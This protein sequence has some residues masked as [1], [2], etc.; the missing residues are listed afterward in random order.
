MNN[1][2]ANLKNAREALGSKKYEDAIK[3]C[4]R[5]LDWESQNY[6][7]YVFLGVAHNGL[8][9]VEDAENA[10]QKAIEINPEQMLAWQGLVSFYEKREQWSKLAITLEKLIDT[11]L[12]AGDGVRLYESIQ[13][14]VDIY[15]NKDADETKFVKALYYYLPGS[16]YYDLLTSAG[17]LPKASTIWLQILDLKSRQ[18]EQHIE[19]EIKARRM[20]INA[21]PPAKLRAQVEAEITAKSDLGNIFETVLQD[22]ES[23]ASAD[24]T[25]I[26]TKYFLFLRKRIVSEKDKS[27]TYLKL[28]KLAEHLC[29]HNVD[30]QEPYEF[31]IESSNVESYDLYDQTFCEQYTA[32]FPDTGLSKLIQGQ[33]LYKAGDGDSAFDFFSD[34][35]EL[36]PESL[37]GYQCLSW[38]YCDSKEYETGLEYS[39][40]GR[41][42]VLQDAKNYGRLLDRVLLSMELCMATCYRKID[43][44]YFPDAMSLYKKIIE[45]FP[46]NIAAKN[47]YGLILSSLNRQQDA[48][49]QFQSILEL[50]AT[51]HSAKVEIG[52]IYCQ[53]GKFDEALSLVE[54]AIETSDEENPEYFYRL[55][56]IYWEMGDEYRNDKEGAYK[57]FIR[58]VKIDPHFGPAF[59]YLGHFYRL[60]SKDHAKAMKCY[61]KALM[62]D[63]ADLDAALHLVDYHIADKELDQA[64][65]ILTDITNLRTRAGWPWRRLGFLRMK[66]NDCLNAIP[67]FQSALRADANDV[68]S[69][70]GLAES[71]LKEGRYTAAMKAFVRA[72]ELAPSNVYTSYQVAV[73]KQ[74]LGLLEEAIVQYSDTLALAEEQQQP[75]YIPALKGLADA[76]VLQGRENFQQ[77]FY[78]RAAD[79]YNA[80][81]N[82]CLRGLEIHPMESFW[83]LVGCTFTQYRTVMSYS[84]LFAFEDLQHIMRLLSPTPNELLKLPED[85]SSDLVAEFLS[86]QIDPDF[87]LPRKECLDVLLSCAT[88]AYKQA[89]YLASKAGS[90]SPSY[91]HDLGLTYHWLAENNLNDIVY[92]D[93][94]KLSLQCIKVALKHDQE[95][96]TF[97]NSLG[98]IA[99][100][101]DVKISQHAFIKSMEYNSRSAIPWSNYGYLCLLQNDLE[102]ASAAF[103]AAQAVDPEWI[104]SWIGQAYVANIWGNSSSTLFEH[105]FDTSNGTILDANYGYASSV[106]SQV[107]LHPHSSDA[108]LLVSPAFALQKLTE[109]NPDNPAAL[110][111]YGLILERL[112]QFGQAAEAYAGSI[113]ALEECMERDQEQA[114]LCQERISKVHANLARVLCANGDFEGAISSYTIA[115]DSLQDDGAKLYCELGAG[116]SYYFNNQLEEAL[117]MFEQ[118]LTNADTQ[119]AEMRQNVSVLLS[120]VLWALGGEEQRDLAQQELFKCI[121]DNPYHLAS[122]FGLC[123]MGLIQ[124]NDTL[125]EAAVQEMM[126]IPFGKAGFI[127]NENNGGWLLSKYHELKGSTEGA[128]QALAKLVHQTPANASLWTAMADQMIG[129]RH[130]NAPYLSS[131]IAVSN[132]S[133]SMLAASSSATAQEKSLAYYDFA[134]A[135]IQQ[136][137][138]NKIRKRK[139]KEAPPPDRRHDIITAAQRAVFLAPWDTKAWTLLGIAKSCMSEPIET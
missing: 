68:L 97:W 32:K 99:L 87:T 43:P 104:S 94:M 139:A 14:L 130:S 30:V 15:Q 29:D 93:H 21:G 6:N 59:T 57:C 25:A 82:A 75:V 9:Q 12:L 34:G 60:V 122:I 88:F 83:Q 50:D 73:V 63:P 114:V 137:E 108:S 103:D 72:R 51:Q 81:L 36:A 98:V 20:R 65:V 11:Y 96:F 102:L 80:A 111:V 2:K 101:N 4:K 79:S 132:T 119:S 27:K 17:S 127:D 77:G 95:N 41:D 125:T 64:E 135:L 26:Q 39:T 76:H 42:L 110:N 71:Y 38:L 56:R 18:E 70:E 126:K 49:D 48:L 89:I 90:V 37:F 7:A 131:T 19:K 136:R 55:G 40:K 138:H 1:T 133:L 106:L 134:R 23:D 54:E 61:Q 129:K 121:G 128:I 62:L 124:D 66:K 10:Y 85:T 117:T 109:Q 5:V 105:A 74:K 8:D 92:K 86:L 115:I 107:S 3:F 33:N 24:V 13:K 118:A 123:A 22:A 91:W 45:K 53:Q 116:I 52:W 44:K 120:Q 78:G 100:N 84:H 28:C 47:G 112:Q 31:L 35:I 58:S 16:K 113:L 67:S 46:E 69:W